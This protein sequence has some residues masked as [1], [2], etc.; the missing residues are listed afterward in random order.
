M[1]IQALMD[2]KLVFFNLSVA[3]QSELFETMSHSLHQYDII[4]DADAF[5]NALNQREQLSTTGLGYGIAIPHAKSDTVRQPTLAVAKLSTPIDYASIDKDK[6]TVVFMI[7]MP[8]G[9]ED[10]YLQTLSMLTRKMTDRAFIKS[11]KLTQNKV[12]FMEILKT[13]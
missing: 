13:I 10:L 9:K 8:K 3:N 5:I 1:K 4:V 12:E 2:E 6:V 7:A 11:L